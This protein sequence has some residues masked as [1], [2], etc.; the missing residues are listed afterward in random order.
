MDIVTS[1]D[2]QTDALLNARALV[3]HDLEATASANPAATG[4][5]EIKNAVPRGALRG[6]ADAVSE[7]LVEIRRPPAPMRGDLLFHRIGLC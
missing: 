1:D 6:G 4:Q 7:I 3:L 2:H 5:N